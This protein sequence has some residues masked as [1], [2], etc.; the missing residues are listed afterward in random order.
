MRQIANFPRR[1]LFVA[2]DYC[3][4][5]LKTREVRVHFRSVCQLTQVDRSGVC[6]F[7]CVRER[8]IRKRHSGT[9]VAIRNSN[10]TKFLR[11]NRLCAFLSSRHPMLHKSRLEGRDELK[12]YQRVLSALKL[13]KIGLY[14]LLPFSPYKV[15]SYLNKH[16][17]LQVRYN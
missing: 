12:N 3:W 10:E 17:A 7:V 5:Y 2:T 4:R 1:Y 6:A 9:L 15:N 8:V 13:L 16:F 11:K 14:G